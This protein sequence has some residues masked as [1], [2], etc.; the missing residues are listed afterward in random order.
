MERLECRTR[1]REREREMVYLGGGIVGEGII[2]RNREM[3][4]VR[5]SR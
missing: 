2:N 3:T 5:D 4:V 1:E